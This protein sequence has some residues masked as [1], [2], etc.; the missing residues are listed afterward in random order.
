MLP[1]MPRSHLLVAL[2]V[3]LFL[4]CACKKSSEQPPTAVPAA[5]SAKAATSASLAEPQTLN[6]RA[7][8]VF[9]ARFATS[10]GDVVIEVHRDW[11][12]VGADRF[13]NLV[14]AGY[15]DET[16]F[17]RVIS[18]FMAQIGIHG[19]PEVNAVWHNQQ[20]QDDP[21]VKSNIRGF[22]TFAKTGAPNSRTTQ[23]F[24]NY[25]DN[26]NLDG[27]GFAPFGEVKSGMEAI[28][29]LFAGYGEGAGAPNQGRLQGEGNAYLLREFPRLDYVKQATILP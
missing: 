15:Y 8:D 19:K 28:D 13:Y 17:F 7:P 5:A 18:G 14:K 16:R 22:V 26:R 6:Q 27:M 29:A 1:V 9:R 11:A 21:V 2:T 25:G 20:I 3:P 23:F 24:I 10:K 4:A 12:P